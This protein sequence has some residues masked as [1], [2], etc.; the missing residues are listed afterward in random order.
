MSRKFPSSFA[1]EIL[2]TIVQWAI[3]SW[4]SFQISLQYEYSL[5]VHPPPLPSQPSLQPQQPGQKPF[6]QPSVITAIQDTVQKGGPQPPVYH[7][8][9]PLQ[10]AEGPMIQQQVAPSEKPPKAEVNPSPEVRSGS[11]TNLMKETQFETH[12][13]SQ[14]FRE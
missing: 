6:H 13:N 9:P 5:P 11:P 1:L 3:A 14:S 10:Q 8:Q 2:D 12:L 7:G 4:H